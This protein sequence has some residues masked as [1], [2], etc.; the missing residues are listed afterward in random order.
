MRHVQ[1][2][3]VLD[4]GAPA[5]P[6]EIDVAADDAVK[7][8]AGFGFDDHVADDDR[9]VFD[10]GGIRDGRGDASVGFNHVRL[11][12]NGFTHAFFIPLLCKPVLSL[13]KG[14]G[15]F[16]EEGKVGR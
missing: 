11:S 12:G 5:D 10:E 8:Y 3:E 6:N 9:G 15:T 13:S 2:R 4:V 14:T 16:S 7:P 1:Q